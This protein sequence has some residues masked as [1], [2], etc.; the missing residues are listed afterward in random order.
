MA[1]TKDRQSLDAITDEQIHK[2]FELRERGLKVNVIATTVGIESSY[3]YSWISR[4][5]KRLI[6]RLRASSKLH[7]IL[8][9]HPGIH[10][11]DKYFKDSM[12]SAEESKSIPV[13]DRRGTSTGYASKFRI[14]IEAKEAE[15]INQESPV[16][17]HMA[18]PDPTYDP[19]SVIEFNSKSKTVVIGS[20]KE[21]FPGKSDITT[22]GDA[23]MNQQ[24]YRGGS[25]YTRG[26]GSEQQL[27]AQNDLAGLFKEGDSIDFDPSNVLSLNIHSNNSLELRD[28][29]VE[30]EKNLVEHLK[31]VRTVLENLDSVEFVL[32]LM[33][34]TGTDVNQ[35]LA[36][37]NAELEAEIARLKKNENPL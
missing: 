22:K 12:I 30:Y 18:V 36:D 5:S 37:R 16:Y 13:V 23:D 28:K 10:E 31:K 29:L 26:R 19:N 11:N 24:T 25:T 2:V 32:G 34:D 7:F 15:E 17:T 14:G 20:D 33:G 4:P 3:I 6:E 9:N 8:D 35:K 1:K 21:V 27:A